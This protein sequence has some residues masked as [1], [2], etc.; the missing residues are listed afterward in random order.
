MTSTVRV[1]KV[2]YHCDVQTQS[3]DFDVLWLQL[4]EVAMVAL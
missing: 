1:K 2:H 4:S 3:Y